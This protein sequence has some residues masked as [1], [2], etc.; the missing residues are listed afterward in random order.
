MVLPPIPVPTTFQVGYYYPHKIVLVAL[1]SK[2]TR[3]FAA[4]GGRK[5]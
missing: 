3:A 2:E 4:A 1:A 5:G